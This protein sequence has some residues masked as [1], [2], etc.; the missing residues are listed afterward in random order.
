MNTQ[1][2]PPSSARGLQA[3]RPAARPPKYLYMSEG[4]TRAYLLARDA[5]RRVQRTS[6]LV[7]ALS[8]DADRQQPA[9]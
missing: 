3:G 9:T 6:T 2:L 8:R 4:Q 5:V 1:S 7:G